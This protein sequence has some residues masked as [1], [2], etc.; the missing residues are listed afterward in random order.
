MHAVGTPTHQLLQTYFADLLQTYC[1]PSFADLMQTYCIV[2]SLI[3]HCMLKCLGLFKK[4]LTILKWWSLILLYITADISR[5]Q[6]LK[7]PSFPMFIFYITYYIFCT[8]LIKTHFNF[9]FTFSLIITHFTWRP[10]CKFNTISC[11][12]M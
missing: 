2:L 1:I 7:R 5:D 9:Y 6:I 3:A 12:A 8:L 10:F 11:I 4:P